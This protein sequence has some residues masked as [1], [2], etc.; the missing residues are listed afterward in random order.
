MGGGVQAGAGQ[1][2]EGWDEQGAEASA[3]AGVGEVDRMLSDSSP[4]GIASSFF[5]GAVLPIVCVRVLARLLAAVGRAIACARQDDT[6]VFI[7]QW[8]DQDPLEE[9]LVEQLLQVGGCSGVEAVAVFEEVKGLSQMLADFSGVGLV[10]GQLALDLVQLGGQLSLFLLEQVKRDG[11]FVVGMEETASSV[12]DVGTPRRQGAHCLGLVPFDLSQLVMEVA[13]DLYSVLRAELD[14]PVELYHPVFD[15]VDEHGGEGAVVEAAAAGADEV[16]VDG[17]LAVLSVLDRQARPA[18][19][20]DDGALEEVVVDALAL[21]IAPR[22]QDG[23]DGLPGLA[24]HQRLVLAGVLHALEGDDAFVVGVAQDL[25]QARCR[26]GLGRAPWRGRDG[27]AER[28][29]MVGQLPHRPVTGRILREGQPDQRCALLIQGD[30][31]NFSAVLVSG[32]DVEVA[33]RCLAQRPTIPGLFSHPLH[34]LI[35]QVPGVELS[36]G[37]HDAVQQHA[38]RRLVDVLAGRH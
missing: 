22:G 28:V 7:D 18:L 30:R 12:L 31:P 13:L 3:G 16:G 37:A 5:S 15:D 11:P 19:A 35:S 14:G 36:D 23:L 33:E 9:D 34:D 38:T 10:G 27:E 4:A 20:A 6:A 2:V 21:P 25:V 8:I 24:V 26:D 1:L 32:A 29:E 17:A